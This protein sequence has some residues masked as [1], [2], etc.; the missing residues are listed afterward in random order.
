MKRC[1]PSTPFTYSTSDLWLA[2]ALIAAKY[3]LTGLRWNGQRAL[4]EFDDALACEMATDA[5]WCGD[6]LVP[7]KAFADSLRTLKDR[8]HG[9]ASWKRDR[10]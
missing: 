9:S 2:A 4:F 8:L 3:R 7:A 5:Y 6:L 10:P 1:I